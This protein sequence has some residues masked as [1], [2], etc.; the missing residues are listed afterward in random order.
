MQL[1]RPSILIGKTMKKVFISFA[2]GAVL[3]VSITTQGQQPTPWLS[4]TERVRFEKLRESGCEA[5]YN[6]D[7][8]RARADFSEMVRLF[9]QHPAGQQYLASTLFSKHFT[10]RAGYSPRSTAQ[11]P[12]TQGAK[13]R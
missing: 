3:L 13:I 11:S 2:I 4:D 8:K 12:S 7:N 5:L 6:L 9:P 1:F 10:N